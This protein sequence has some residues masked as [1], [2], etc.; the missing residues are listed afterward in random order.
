MP[1]NRRG[2]A[3]GGRPER[4]AGLQAV[5]QE[6]REL[7]FGNGLMHKKCNRC[8][9]VSNA[10]ELQSFSSTLAL[11]MAGIRSKLVICGRA[12]RALSPPRYRCAF[13][14]YPHI[15]DGRRSH[16]LTGQCARD[17]VFYGPPRPTNC[18]FSLDSNFPHICIHLCAGQAYPRRAS[19][20]SGRRGVSRNL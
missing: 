6:L 18:G 12:Q 14:M 16:F 20:R 7:W 19:G 13:I 2:G 11:A 3:L 9:E 5:R 15:Y 1:G 10:R 8:A 17:R 4:A